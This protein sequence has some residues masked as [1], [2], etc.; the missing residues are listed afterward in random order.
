M[1]I[2]GPTP[3]VEI[4]FDSGPYVASPTWVDVTSYVRSFSTHRGR[5]SDFD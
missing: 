2:H 5:S 3:T 1:P 4:S